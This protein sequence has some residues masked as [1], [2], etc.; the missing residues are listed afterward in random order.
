MIFVDSETVGL[1]G[2]AILL[3]YAENDNEITFYHFWKRSVQESLELIEWLMNYK[4]G[5]IFFNAVFDHFQLCK[6]YTMFLLAKN[7]DKVPDIEEMKS[8]E[9]EARDGPCLKPYSIFDVFLHA[10]K[11]SFQSTMERKDIVVRRVP[12]TLAFQLCNELNKRIPLKD[13]YFARK[14][15]RK[16]WEVVDTPQNEWKNVVLKFA[17]SSGLKALAVDALGVPPEEI[18]YYSDFDRGLPK[19][20]ELHYRP[21]GGNWPRIIQQYI[22]HWWEA[23]REKNVAYKYAANDIIYLRE[24]YKYFE[25]PPMNDNDSVLACLVAAV[26]WKGYNL[27]IK[28]IHDL[29]KRLA[30]LIRE[31]PFDPNHI[32]SAPIQAKA[33]IAQAMEPAERIIFE[34]N[35]ST[36]KVILKEIIEG[37]GPAA[38]RAQNVVRVRD[39]KYKIMLLDKL[40]QAGRF[41]ADLKI[42]GTL[43]GRMGG[44]SGKTG[45]NPQGIPREKEIRE[46]FTFATEGYTLCGGDEESFEV[47]LAAAKYGDPGLT[48]VLSKCWKCGYQYKIGEFLLERCPECGEKDSRTKLHALYGMKLFPG[49]TYEEVRKD[50]GK[51]TRAKS[52]VFSK[53]YGG[54]WQTMVQKYGI[55]EHEARMADYKFNQDYPEI[56][57]ARKKT[58]GMFQSM[59]Q[60]EGL[61]TKVVWKEPVDKIESMLGFPRYF[62]LENM[63]CK[64]LFDL[65]EHIP[66][67]WRDVKIPVTRK[68]R[69]QMVSGAV[70]SALFACAFNIQ[71]QNMRAAENHTIQSTGAQITKS[72]QVEI[73]KHQP[74]GINPWIVAPLNV[75][76]EIIT[77]VK[78]G[79]ED[80][81]KQTVLEKNESYRELISLICINWKIGLSDWGE[82]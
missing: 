44:G 63:I 43:S 48:E 36:K 60:P 18:L 26:R 40:L 23:D 57:K 56:E 65:A 73:W 33:Y 75:H 7:K 70:Q 61:G 82:K 24:L 9:K 47:A 2:P 17:A 42:I 66:S 58:Q 34:N 5:L 45:I 22:D 49:M 80:L 4:D 68:D 1:C 62:T 67:T 76:D 19:V 54:D 81:V 3:Q 72:I 29:R 6:I 14:K 35:G 21:F 79:Y 20:H 39:A 27:D 64:A 38:E 46:C 41:H 25:S 15:D 78:K 50:K 52:C 74:V 13:I 8:V 55:S 37:D 10:R 77:P 51:Y 30:N 59:S 11:T 71:A 31:D 69:V 12:T 32:P 53:I 16:R 28:K